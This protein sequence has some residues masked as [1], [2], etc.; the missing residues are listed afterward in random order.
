MKFNGINWDSVERQIRHYGKKPPFD[1]VVIDDFFDHKFACLL[2]EE[3]PEFES[4]VWHDYNNPLEIK[5]TSN[6][7]NFFPEKT[8]S[9]FAY[10]NS[11]YWLDFLSSNILDGEKLYGDSGLNG[12]GWHAH[13]KG[14]KLNTHL[15]YSLHPKLLLQRKLNIIIYINPDWKEEWG[16]S[17]GFW[18]NKSPEKPGKLVTS[19]WSKFNRAVIFDTTQNS[20]HGLPEPLQCPDHQVRRSIAAYFLCE[21]KVGVDERGKAMFAPTE[22][23]EGDNEILELIKKRSQNSTASSVYKKE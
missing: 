20:W 12:G 21:P 22:E 3:F 11:E 14:G 23:Q 2:A 17:L 15:D 9:T 18:D 6:N 16:G 1:H 19:V 13:K 10:F 4:N 5:K 8:Y 7:W